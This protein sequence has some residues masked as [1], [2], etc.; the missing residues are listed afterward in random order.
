MLDVNTS[1]KFSILYLA[2]EIIIAYPR[3]ECSEYFVIFEAL[4][5]ASV[6][7]MIQLWSNHIAIIM[8][9]IVT[10]R[11]IY[12]NTRINTSYIIHKK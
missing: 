10:M 4:E 8:N 12:N 1:D 5:R 3:S 7:Q 2:V 11:R 9:V 6:F